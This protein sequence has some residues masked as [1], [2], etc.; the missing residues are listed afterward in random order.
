MKVTLKGFLKR[1]N[2]WNVDLEDLPDLA[3][4]NGEQ[5]QRIREQEKLTRDEFAYYLGIKSHTVYLLEKNKRNA[6]RSLTL[7]IHFLR[8]G[9]IKANGREK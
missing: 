1:N 2:I 6:S 4:L 8:A 3:S 5:I 7:L 9:L